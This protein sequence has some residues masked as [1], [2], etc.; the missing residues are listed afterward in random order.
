MIDP[1]WFTASSSSLVSMLVSTLGIYIAL[2][3]F[4][5]LSGLRSFS[6]MSSFDFAITVAFGS[7]LASTIL[8]DTPALATGVAGLG[9]LYLIQYAVARSRRLSRSI[10]RWVD[11]EPMVLMVGDQMLANNMDAARVTREDLYSKVR[12]AGIIDLAQVLAVVM[13]S[14]GD[15][16]VLEHGP[17]I[18]ARLFEGV[19]DGGRVL[20]Q[21]RT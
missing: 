3:L 19:R 2:M 16:S 18:D 1:A 10:E 12:M 14:T 17:N 4:T 9:L 21:H 5:R 7:I 8:S 11:N 15:I 13:E 20:D 6:K